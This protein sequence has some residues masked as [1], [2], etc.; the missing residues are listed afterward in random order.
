MNAM[1]SLFLRRYCAPTLDSL[2]ARSYN[3]VSDW[4]KLPKHEI[5]ISDILELSVSCNNDCMW[6]LRTQHSIRIGVERVAYIMYA[7]T[8]W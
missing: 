1:F 8:I 7:E 2:L 5:V 3:D 4:L 6:L